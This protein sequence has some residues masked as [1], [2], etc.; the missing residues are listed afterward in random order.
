MSFRERLLN[1]LEEH[2]A[3]EK[4]YKVLLETSPKTSDSPPMPHASDSLQSPQTG[5][6]GYNDL[7]WNESNTGAASSSDT[8][9]ARMSMPNHCKED[10]VQDTEEDAGQTSNDKASG[11]APGA[12]ITSLSS[13]PK[14]VRSDILARHRRKQRLK[15]AFEVT[16]SCEREEQ[17]IRALKERASQMGLH[18]RIQHLDRRSLE[19]FMDSVVSV[20]IT[21]NALFIGLQMDHSNDTGVSVWKVLDLSFSAFFAIEIF[22]KC[23]LQG[24]CVYFCGPD[25]ISNFFDACLIG[26]DLVQ[27]LAS[28]FGSVGDNKDS[29]LPHASLLRVIRLIRLIRLLRLFRTNLFQDLVAMLQGMKAGALTLFWAVVVFGMSVYTVALICRSIFGHD[30]SITVMPYFDSVPRSMYTVFRCSFGDCSSVSGTPIPE[31]IHDDLG[32]FYA[33]LYCIF[34]FLVTIGLFNIISA[35]FV[36]ATV[37]AAAAGALQRANGRLEDEKRWA[38]NLTKI[39]RELLQAS[40]SVRNMPLD[41]L[42]TVVD[43]VVHVEFSRKTIEDVTLGNQS[44]RESLAQLDINSNDHKR[45]SDILDPDHSGTVTVLELMFGLQR[46]R[47]E[48]RR[49]DVVCVDLMVRSLQERV[50]EVHGDISA[51]NEHMNTVIQAIFSRIEAIGT[52]VGAAN[53]D[54]ILL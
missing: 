31:H 6:L 48:P 10:A 49:S 22:L 36:D 12:S 3:L 38:T 5:G 34:S 50:D 42:S 17:T 27:L 52:G 54:V 21:L 41:K 18:Q 16:E 53:T 39:I 37:T 14:V 33:L 28:L 47:G 32:G 40:E 4:R 24:P 51:H 26:A 23:F 29:G 1:L 35:I 46:L 7:K 9:G 43:E 20:V 45:L 15:R 13:D 25:K 8:D 19:L 11:V 30:N 2:E 44:V